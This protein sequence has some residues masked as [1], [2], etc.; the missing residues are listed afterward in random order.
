[1][2]RDTHSAGRDDGPRPAGPRR[3]PLHPVRPTVFVPRVVAYLAGAA[4]AIPDVAPGAASS[5][6]WV[7]M[8]LAPWCGRLPVPLHL[9]PG[10]RVLEDLLTP[11][12]ALAAGMPLAGVG[13]LAFVFMV[14]HLNVNGPRAALECAVAWLVLALV[15]SAFGP[16]ALSGAPAGLVGAGV[17][18]LLF[19]LAAAAL[20][21]LQSMRLQAAREALARQA[22]RQQAL[23]ERLARYLPPPVHRAAFEDA[24]AGRDA[25]QGRSRRRWLTV[26]FADL[27][28]FTALTDSAQSEEVVTMLDDFYTAMA[29]AALAHGGTL[30]K[31]IG[32]AVMVFFGDPGTRGRH[33]DARACV[34]MAA[35]MQARFAILRRRWRATGIVRDLGLRVGIH[36]GW[37]TV[38]DFGHATRMAYTVIGATVNAASR[39]EGAARAGQVLLSRTCWLLL[40]DRAGH[41]RRVGPVT[42][43]GFH[44]PIEAFEYLGPEHRRAPLRLDA[45]GLRVHLEPAAVNPADARRVLAEAVAALPA[46]QAQPDPG[47][48]VRHIG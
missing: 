21:H 39:L 13:A 31:F 34:A 47:A 3:Q 48:P 7:W 25:G 28:G 30:D 12:L 46:E 40:G 4:L 20:S 44:Q 6:F 27:A 41:C 24:G 38:G 14:G 18:M 8:V 22:Q 1:M 19:A 5:L 42:A 29:E 33:A 23:A 37:C 32:D 35:D 26:C 2:D 15:A 43:K 17:L 9:H 10:L 11:G 16:F 36:S 45:D